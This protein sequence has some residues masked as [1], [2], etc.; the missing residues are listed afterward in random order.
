MVDGRG[1]DAGQA[2]VFIPRTLLELFLFEQRES[3]VL[4]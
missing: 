1:V 3:S 4:I 2:P